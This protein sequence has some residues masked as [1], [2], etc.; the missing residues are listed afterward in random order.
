MMSTQESQDKTSNRNDQI[1]ILSPKGMKRVFML[2][3]QK[4]AMNSLQLIKSDSSEKER[5]ALGKIV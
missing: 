4:S 3:I 5:K 2:N 1:E